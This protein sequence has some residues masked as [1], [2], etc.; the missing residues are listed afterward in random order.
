MIN[1]IKESVVQYTTY[2]VRVSGP[3]ADFEKSAQFALPSGL[4]NEDVH[5]EALDV[6]RDMFD[7]HIQEIGEQVDGCSNYSVGAVWDNSDGVIITTF[8]CGSHISGKS[9]RDEAFGAIMD[10]V[11]YDWVESGTE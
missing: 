6:I 7:M 4:Y 11:S 9:L 1:E 8:E 10:E 2:T 3:T 5:S